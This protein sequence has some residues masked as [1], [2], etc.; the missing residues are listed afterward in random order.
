M[1]S[2]LGNRENGTYKRYEIGR[3]PQAKGQDIGTEKN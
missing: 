1:P 3:K 2:Q